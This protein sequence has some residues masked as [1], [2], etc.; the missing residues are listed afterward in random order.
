MAMTEMFIILT[1]VVTFSWFPASFGNVLYLSCPKIFS[2][3][4]VNEVTCK[5]DIA[6][7]QAAQCVSA[8]KVDFAIKDPA[9]AASKSLTTCAY[10]PP[11]GCSK[12]SVIPDNN[13]GCTYEDSNYYVYTFKFRA[14]KTQEGGQLSTGLCIFPSG[15][16]DVAADSSCDYINFVNVCNDLSCG[17]GV[18]YTEGSP[19][20]AACNCDGTFTTGNQCQHPIAAIIVPIIIIVIIVVIVT[21]FVVLK[22]LKEKKKQM[23]VK[24]TTDNASNEGPSEQQEG[25]GLTGRGVLKK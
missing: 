15:P 24:N 18:C 14:N 10:P 17:P 20:Q 16:Y 25:H 11:S 3:T 23:P 7:L 2:D 8:K 13:C 21:A 1:S 4:D 9:A 6:K 19:P 22:K 5:I 12:S